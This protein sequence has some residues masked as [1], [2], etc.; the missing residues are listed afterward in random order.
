MTMSFFVGGGPYCE[1]F[2]GGGVIKIA[3]RINCLYYVDLYIYIYIYM[4]KLDNVLNLIRVFS[5]E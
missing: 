5:H 2:L 4:S 3:V 1:L